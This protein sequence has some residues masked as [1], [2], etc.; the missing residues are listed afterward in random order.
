MEI[1]G[2]HQSTAKK[3]HQRLN[4]ELSKILN[5]KVPDI[6]LANS[7]LKDS[8]IY[9]NI[10]EACV[11]YKSCGT[12]NLSTKYDPC[13]ILTGDLEELDFYNLLLAILITLKE[14][15][16]DFNSIPKLKEVFINEYSKINNNLEDMN[17]IEEKFNYYLS[18]LN[19]LGLIYGRYW[20]NTY[21]AYFRDIDLV[22]LE[23][24]MNTARQIANLILNNDKEKTY[25]KQ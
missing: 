6:R 22:G 2:F 19:D 11:W 12:T 13:Y 21:S 7:D 14:L 20:S 5:I 3:E 10:F 24:Y 4:T 23:K 25:I 8:V 16:K 17:D 18:R 15:D 9:T 1:D